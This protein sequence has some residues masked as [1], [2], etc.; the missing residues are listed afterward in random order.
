VIRKQKLDWANPRRTNPTSPSTCTVPGQTPCTHVPSHHQASPFCRPPDF[1]RYS[2]VFHN[3]LNSRSPTYHPVDSGSHHPFDSHNP[4]R[5][6]CCIQVRSQSPSRSVGC[7]YRRFQR[8]PTHACAWSSMDCSG[9]Y[10]FG[11]HGRLDMVRRR[12]RPGQLSYAVCHHLD[13]RPQEVDGDCDVWRLCVVHH[14]HLLTLT[15]VLHG[16]VGCTCLALQL[17]PLA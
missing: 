10:A 7:Q 12:H 6:A 8:F 13:E 9:S 3:L 17:K 14:L 2:T 11:G 1:G 16:G 4:A 15:N 5:E